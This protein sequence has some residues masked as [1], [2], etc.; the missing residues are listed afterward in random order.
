MS[1]RAT[2][3]FGTLIAV[4]VCMLSCVPE[5]LDVDNIPTV[6]PEIVVSSQIV[7]DESLVVLL[8]RTF[9][10]LQP[11]N[12]SVPEELLDRIAITDAEVILTGPD[13]I[14]TLLNLGSGFYGGVE[15][16]F[17][18][19]QE[20]TLLVNTP[21]L[22]AVTATTRVRPMVSFDDIDASLYYNGFDDTLAQ[23]SHRI[24]DPAGKNQYMVNV[25]EV[26]REDVI[27]NLINPR[28]FLRLLDDVTFEGQAYSEV[29]RVVPRDY[30]PGDTIA[31]SLSNISREYYDFLRLR[32]DNR[33]SFVEY[34]GEPIN[35]PSNVQGGRGMFNLFIPDVRFFVL[36]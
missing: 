10:A 15:I 33:F 22:G 5:P 35:Y 11:I 24:L 36:E 32:L 19:G 3:I 1:Q 18:A 27:S 4:V 16:P 17:E 23:I 6:E 20:Y 34:L 9:S 21:T 26:E 31:V 30:H 25:Q 12:D 14:D 8:T 28:A 2:T 29:F 7:P 13:G